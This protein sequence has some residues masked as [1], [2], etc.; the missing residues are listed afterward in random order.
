MFV[1]NR[2]ATTPHLTHPNNDPAAL[3]LP[4]KLAE[5][6]LHIVCKVFLPVPIRE[7][8]EAPCAPGAVRGAGWR[9]GWA[10]PSPGAHWL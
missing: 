10:M 5:S 2:D 4:T 1:A 9:A 8:A 3:A 6:Y 7:G